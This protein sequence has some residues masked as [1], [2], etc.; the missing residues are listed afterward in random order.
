MAAPRREL[1]VAQIRELLAELGN[2]LQSQGVQA[3]LYIVGGAAIALEFDVRRVTA[4][5]D[6]V[7]HPATTVRAEAA[8][9]ATERGLPRNWLNDSVRSFVPGGDDGAVRLD[10]PGLSVALASPEH[11]L[12]MKLA[13][14]RPGQD[15]RD[16]ELLFGALAIGSAGDAADLAL[17]V[18]GE[19]S[20]VLPGRDELVLSAQAIIDRRARRRR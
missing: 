2:R 8:R 9:M 16:L 18:Y 5:V 6:A 4:D 11:L 1:S 17:R 19:A 15:Q 13:A 12:A 3:S 10:V 7:F 14:Y 20:V